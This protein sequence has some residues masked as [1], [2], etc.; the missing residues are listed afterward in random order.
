M[1]PAMV[2]KKSPK[3]TKMPYSS[4][5]K[6]IRGQRIRMSRMPVRKAAVPAIFWRRAKN[7][8]VFWRPI[9]RVRPQMKRIYYI[10]GLS[11]SVVWTIAISRRGTYVAHC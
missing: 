3:R 2:A 1:N 4:T 8:S 11:D 5:T 6:P 7:R 10:G 9:R